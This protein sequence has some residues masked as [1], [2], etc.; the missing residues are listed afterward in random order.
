MGKKDLDMPCLRAIEHALYYYLSESYMVVVHQQLEVSALAC[1]PE[2]YHCDFV[3]PLVSVLF[4][5]CARLIQ[6]KSLCVNFCCTSYYALADL[7]DLLMHMLGMRDDNMELLW[8][9]CSCLQDI[10]IDDDYLH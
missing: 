10:I 1:I 6:P 8:F 9:E 3:K 4:P 2:T 7:S 5:A